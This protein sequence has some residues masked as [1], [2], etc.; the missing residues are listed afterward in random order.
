MAPRRPIGTLD[1]HE[2]TNQPP[3]FEDACLFASDQ[4]LTSAVARAGGAQH[5]SRLSAFGQRAGSAEVLEWGREANRVGPALESFD[6]YGRR[7]DEVRFHP[8]Y[9]R[10]MA[11][12]LNAGIASAPWGGDVPAGHV[13]HAALSFILGQ[14]DAGVVC[15]MTM[16]YAS[17][18]AL[19]ANP[20]IDAEWTPRI[21]AAR[22]D[23]ACRPA[24]EKLGVTL[25]MAMTE[26]QGGSDLRANTTLAEA[27]DPRREVFM[28]TGHKWFCSAPMSDAFLTL[29]NT[30][31]GLTCLL[32]P[33]WLPDGERNRGFRIMQLKD[34]LGDRSNA[35]SEI[36]YHGAVAWRIGEEGRGVATILPMVQHT[37]LDCVI[38]SAAT[39]RAALVQALWHARHRLAFHKALIDQPAMRAVLADLAVESEAAT[40]LGFRLAAAVDAGEPLARVLTPV[41][42]YWVCKRAPGF[43]YEA[44]ECLGGAGYV[45]TGPL[46]RLFRASPLNAIWEGSSNII[47]LDV[48]RAL[49]REP[50]AV[51]GLRDLLESSAGRDPAYDAARAGLDLREAEEGAARHTVERIAVLAQA[52]VL[53]AADSPVAEAFCRL[54]LDAPS[55]AYGASGA[56]IDP[57]A[58]IDRAWPAGL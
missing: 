58:V 15:P 11:L 55:F 8:A 30:E 24:A 33:R 10:L 54:R 36:E 49:Q 25:G 34:K 42:K 21:L 38:G 4:A 23:P 12:G 14:V 20:E 16:T 53:L 57:G 44:M 51:A 31:R 6:P 39:M 48:R 37:R 7:I 13:L 28:L 43:V 1:T 35:S 29:A 47:A 18:P 3:P 17:V 46:P 52:A 2:V 26:K 9:H 45:E 5:A 22:Y 19:R 27:L 56:V 40:A 32:A 50:E 41:A